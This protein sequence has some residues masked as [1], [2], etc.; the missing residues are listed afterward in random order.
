MEKIL[1]IIPARGG[2]KGL[3]GKN[4]KLLCGKPLIAYS[5]EAIKASEYSIDIVISTDSE[6]I[7]DVGNDFGVPSIIRPLELATDTS[8]V[9]DA[10]KYTIN[11]LKKQGREYDILLLIEPTSPLRDGKDIDD[12]LNLLLK[13]KEIDCVATYSELEHPVTRLWSIKNNTPK[14]LIPGADPFKRRQ[15]Q[16]FGYY[17]NGLV[18][19]LR[20]LNLEK[21]N[22]QSFFQGNIGA[23]V[24]TKRV[25][26]ID[27]EYDFFIAEQLMKYKNKDNQ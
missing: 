13:S 19:A 15:D 17:I 26:D 5:I 7:A 14:V 12:A 4:I 11:S 20:I 23:V 10:V 1:A 3:P 21:H 6:Q 9:I 18:Y 24:T 25:V 27:N 2:S 8:L 16:S 22:Y